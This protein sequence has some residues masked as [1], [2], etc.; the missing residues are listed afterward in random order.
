MPYLNKSVQIPLLHQSQFL[1]TPRRYER[2]VMGLRANEVHIHV[3][4]EPHSSSHTFMNLCLHTDNTSG[5]IFLKVSLSLMWLWLM[6]V[7]QTSAQVIDSNLKNKNKKISLPITIHT[8][9]AIVFSK[10]QHNR[11]VYLKIRCQWC[12]EVFLPIQLE[13]EDAVWTK[14]QYM[15]HPNHT[16]INHLD[17]RLLL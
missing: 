12:F 17:S 16:L 10:F 7:L 2:F 15:G 1:R 14:V 13:R 9:L 8:H 4:W 11:Q 6:K 3:K 5:M